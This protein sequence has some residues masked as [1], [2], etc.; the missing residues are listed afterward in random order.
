M[1]FKETY[2]SSGFQLLIK[3]LTITQHNCS[4]NHFYNVMYD[5]PLPYT[6]VVIKT[7]FKTF[8]IMGVLTKNSINF[9]RKHR[10]Q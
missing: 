10:S 8:R 7:F 3:I 1:P 5:V 9:D 2:L 6:T 4:A